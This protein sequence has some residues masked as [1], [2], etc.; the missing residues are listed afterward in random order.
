MEGVRTFLESSTIHGLTYISTTRRLVKLLWIVIVIAGFTGA[1]IMIYQSF[2][3]WDESPVKTTIETLPIKNITFPKVTVCPP[4]NTFTNLNYDLMI[5]KN[6]T[7]DNNTQDE[8]TNFAVGQL[9]NTI[10]ET[11]HLKLNRLHDDNRYYNW[12]KGYSR[13]SVPTSEVFTSAP[14]GS[15]YTPFF[16]EKFDAEKI[17]T[18]I[19][20]RIRFYLPES[21]QRIFTDS[22]YDPQ[23]I[24]CKSEASTRAPFDI[25]LFDNIDTTFGNSNIG[26][27]F[28]RF[29]MEYINPFSPCKKHY[30]TGYRSHI[31]DRKMYFNVQIDMVTMKDISSGKDELSIGKE[32]IK[33]GSRKIEKV[34]S[35]NDFQTFTL[36]GVPGG[37]YTS[38][39]QINLER[40]VTLEDARTLDLDVMPGFNVTWYY[41]V[42]DYLYRENATGKKNYSLTD[43]NYF[44]HRDHHECYIGE[45]NTDFIFRN[46]EEVKLFT[47]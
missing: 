35:H 18:D 21:V 5:M 8:L 16:G 33:P 17:D 43:F 23:C 41:T 39:L 29:G 3:S 20:Y 30:D 2:Q 44:Y 47:R 36:T 1:G 34:F 22:K 7:L 40:K 9:E 38:Y 12:Y 46:T 4:K 14:L 13:W 24:S 11:V 25:P 6:L 32:Y 31:Q 26:Q 37:G 45:G 19:S 27:R 15:L 10:S 28:K 42:E